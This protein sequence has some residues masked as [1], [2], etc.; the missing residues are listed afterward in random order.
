MADI[1]TKDLVKR[2]VVISSAVTYPNKKYWSASV[3]I[4]YDY[5]GI[6]DTIEKAYC[7]LTSKIFNSDFILNQLKEYTSFKQLFNF[8]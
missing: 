5:N 3:T 7:D 2:W 6:G 1:I 8:R 4:G